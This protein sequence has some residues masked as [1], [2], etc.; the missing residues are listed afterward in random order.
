VVGTTS[1]KGGPDSTPTPV[2]VSAQARTAII[3][4]AV[5]GAVAIILGALYVG[6]RV[7]AA[8]SAGAVTVWKRDG[9]RAELWG[10]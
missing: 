2:V 6:K 9:V 7:R 10:A 3:V 1:A 4:V 8:E 5:F